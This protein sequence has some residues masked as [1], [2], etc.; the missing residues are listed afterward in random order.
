MHA[1]D[2][3]PHFFEPD[4]GQEL[5]HYTTADAALS[6]LRSNTFWLSEYSKT[7]DTSEFIYARDQFLDA[8]R[9][10]TVWIE[11]VPRYLTIFALTGLQNDTMMF[12]GCL[13]TENNDLNQWKS[14]GDGGRGCVIGL[15]ARH[16][17]ERSGV[18]MRRVV[19]DKADLS[20]FANVGLQML[21]NQYEENA[22]D[23]KELRN[24]A[25][26]CVADL[27]AFKHPAFAQENEVRISRLL[28][29][30]ESAPQGLRDVGGHDV[31]DKPLP[32]LSVNMRTG[33]YGRTR[34]VELPLSTS[35]GC[36]AI[37][38]LG[39]GPACPAHKQ[40][41]VKVLISKSSFPVKTWTSDIPFR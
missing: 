24:L 20:H 6:I 34:Y 11:E 31:D 5:Y 14:Y 2:A 15:D 10:R 35:V 39:F 16:L 13:T 18:A 9:E 23:L 28:V 29:N 27:F 26:F 7:N 19:Y 37:R 41:E 40:T 1:S 8:Y 36:S 4:F 33:V 32:Q 30:D 38:S 3:P 25:C 22:N 17:L 21:Q 12:I